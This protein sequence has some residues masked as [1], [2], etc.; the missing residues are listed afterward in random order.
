[1]SNF[2]A[3]FALFCILGAVSAQYQ[4]TARLYSAKGCSG[5]FVNIPANKYVPNLSSLGFDN[6]AYS[7]LLR[8]PWL[9]FDLE[10]YNYA[11]EGLM[12]YAFESSEKC[13]DF[14]DIGGFLTS[15][16]Y[17][18]HN[19]DYRVDTITFYEFTYFQAAEELT[20][21][22]LPNLALVGRISSLI[23]TGSSAWTIYNKPN[24][25]GSAV[26]LEIAPS[27][28]YEP[29]FV[30][31]TI[32]LDPSVPHGFVASVRK[33]CHTSK[34]L[35]LKRGNKDVHEKSVSLNGAF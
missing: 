32:F 5:A 7:V 13:V 20:H 19:S 27:P 34:V 22:D 21:S 25:Q 4:P 2:S 6:R 11:S 24:Y 29:A 14:I 17:S 1:M 18:G 10:N 9:F 8:G 30:P 26:C 3:L 12:E 16:K 23:V 33:G 15:I 31:D 28:Y 35:T